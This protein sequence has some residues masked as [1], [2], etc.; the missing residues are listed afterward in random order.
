MAESQYLPFAYGDGAN[1]VSQPDWNADPTREFGFG[2]GRAQSSKFNKAWRQAATVAAGVSLFIAEYSN[3]D[4]VDDGDYVRYK[5]MFHQALYDAFG[6]GSRPITN[7]IGGN[8]I[9]AVTDQAAVTISLIAPVSV[10]N[11]GTGISA[12]SQGD[13]IYADS[14]TALARLTK[15]PGGYRFLTNQGPN[16]NPIWSLFDISLI[17]SGIGSL[18]ISSGGT[19]ATTGYGALDNLSGAAGTVSGS[20]MRN[21]DGSWIVQPVGTGLGFPVMTVSDTAPTVPHNGDLWMDG[22]SAQLFVYVDDGTS[23]QWVVSNTPPPATPAGL[24]TKTIT[25]AYTAP[26]EEDGVHYNNIGA[27]ADNLITL[28]P[29]AANVRFAAVVFAAF[30]FGFRAAAGDI[31]RRGPDNSPS[32]GSIQSNIPGAVVMLEAHGTGIWVVSVEVGGWSVGA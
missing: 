20:L 21:T 8:G 18:P 19:G 12:Y 23:K 11:G 14:P 4:V 2:Q 28:P 3:I 31:I 9:S 13:L 27:T 16:N 7:V 22:V 15:N 32:A 26:I 24:A 6:G 29:A 17:G 30:N 1:I 10:S 25:S 5:E